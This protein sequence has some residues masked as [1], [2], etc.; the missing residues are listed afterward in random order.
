[1]RRLLYLTALPVL[2]TLVL[3]PLAIA[4]DQ[5]KEDVVPEIFEEQFE[6]PQ[7]PAAEN[8]AEGQREA[9]LEEQVETRQGADLSSLQEAALERQAEA[10]NQQ[11]EELPKE[12]GGAKKEEK[13]NLPNTGGVSGGSLLALGAGVLIVGGGLLV[14]KRHKL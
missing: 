4:Q 12:K 7:E 11:P 5:Y 6:D 14:V 9:A 8:V 2:T 13:K 10:G 3:A 1:M